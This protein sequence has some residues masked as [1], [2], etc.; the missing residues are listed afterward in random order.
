MMTN[1]LKARKQ[2]SHLERNEYVFSMTKSIFQNDTAEDSLRG[3][4]VTNLCFTCL[5]NKR[6]VS[7][8]KSV[9]LFIQRGSL[10]IYEQ[11]PNQL[12]DR[13]SLEEPHSFPE[14][15]R[16][17]QG[18][19]AETDFDNC[20]IS[21]LVRVSWYCKEI[22]KHGE[23]TLSKEYIHPKSATKWTSAVSQKQPTSHHWCSP[24]QL[25]GF[26]TRGGWSQCCITSNRKNKADWSS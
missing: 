15:P 11:F 9:T 7:M 5:E 12:S 22:R 23:K 25:E 10:G 3:H 4:T 16:F 17:K 19:L 24:Q 18:T 8:E 13:E 6:L 2:N 1:S 21:S 20:G 26:S 14:T